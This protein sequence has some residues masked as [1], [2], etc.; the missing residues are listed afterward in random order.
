MVEFDIKILDAKKKKKKND[1]S[2]II[3]KVPVSN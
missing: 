1:R 3:D 2:L